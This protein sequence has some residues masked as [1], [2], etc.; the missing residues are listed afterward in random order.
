MFWREVKSM[1]KSKKQVCQFI[2]GRNRTEGIKGSIKQRGVY[3]QEKEDP[4]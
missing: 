3:F 1:R 2:K 4:L